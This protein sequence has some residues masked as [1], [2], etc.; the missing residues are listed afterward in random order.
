MVKN[1]A[2]AVSNKNNLRYERKLVVPN[3]LHFDIY[4]LIK[5]HPYRFKEIFG[6]RK[7]NNIYFDTSDYYYYFSNLIGNKERTKV[8]IRWYGKFFGIINP[9]LE[10]KKKYGNVG[11]KEFFKLDNSE[12]KDSTSKL[13]ILNFFNTQS[14]SKN[15]K[16][17]SKLLD[18][19]LINSY[20]R[21]YFRSLDNRFRITV[22]YRIEYFKPG[23]LN[24]I[25]K[26]SVFQ[27]P[28]IILEIKYSP[29]D[30]YLCSQI[31][32]YFPF[33]LYKNSKYIN[34]IMYAIY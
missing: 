31:T 5:I 23:N 34:G 6:E 16:S 30:E 10:L 26:F 15:I 29:E 11:Y 3:Q 9:V 33:R 4:N 2:E 8:R 1:M 19:T 18:I 24:F 13:E 21:R 22:D 20:F 14:I 17:E 28:N 7:I 27:D 12:I 32:N 25:N